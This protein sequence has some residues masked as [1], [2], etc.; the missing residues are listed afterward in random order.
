MTDTEWG[1]LYDD[2]T[3][4]PLHSDIIARR[5]AGHQPESRWL[6]KREVR[7]VVGPWEKVTE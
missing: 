1:V 6:V 2:D 5:I 3:I 4:Q 7:R